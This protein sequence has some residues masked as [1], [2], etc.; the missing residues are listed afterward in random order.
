MKEI[1]R[2]RFLRSTILGATLVASGKLDLSAFAK[3][4]VQTGETVGADSSQPTV[5]KL[6]LDKLKVGGRIVVPNDADY[7]VAREDYNGRFSSR[8]KCIVY[9]LSEQDVVETVK[10][11]RE[12]NFSVSIRS[13]GHSYEGFSLVDG[14]VVIDV[15]KMDKISIDTARKTATVGCGVALMQLY[16]TLWEKRLV[17]PGG[18]CSSV[19]IAG[20][21]LG[22]GFGL[23]A[24]NMGLTCDNLIG[25]RMV[26]ATGN[27]VEG[28]EHHNPDLLWACR[29]GGGG[30]FG[31]ITEFTFKTHPIQNVTIFR[32]KWKY[33]DMASV[34]KT[35]Q[36]WAPHADNRITCVLTMT[37]K[38]SNRV[39]CV[40]VFLGNQIEVRK[41]IAPLCAGPKPLSVTVNTS[42][43]MEAVMRFSGLPKRKPTPAAARSP[44]NTKPSAA[45]VEETQ[46]D[47]KSAAKTSVAPAAISARATQPKAPPDTVHMHI[48]AR[49]KNT[50]DYVNKDLDDEGIK[51][52]VDFLTESPVDSSC[53]QFDSYGGKITQLPVKESA[54]CHRADT[55]FCMHYQ[56]SWRNPA[57]DERNMKWVNDFKKAMKPHVSGFAYVNYCDRE[58]EDWGRAYYGDNLER[59][60]EV[61]QKYDPENF[62]SFAQSIPTRNHRS[63]QAVN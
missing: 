59:L 12:N 55:K 28:N 2:R 19:G 10:W 9:C 11:A 62:F 17:V 38:K 7:E 6:L 36:K 23:L 15:S 48:H 46:V 21:T 24:R 31:V 53:L 52:I 43:W 61:K 5:A 22:G 3:D 37:S 63:H 51:T 14:G 16:E 26:D 47:T 20:S 29:G 60:I 13:G 58:I 33:D 44:I 49:F 8:P 41:L 1:S 34:I 35:W 57:Q 27:I 18:S 4:D 54:F 40:G 56:V 50:S 32:V 30:N 25:V 39:S 42:T 45:P